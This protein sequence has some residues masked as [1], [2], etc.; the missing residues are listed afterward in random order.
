MR[1]LLVHL[2]TIRILIAQH[3][4]CKFNHHHLHTQTNAKSRYVNRS[5][6]F[7]SNNLT[8]Y[9]ALPET[10]TND[11]T[12]HTAKFLSHILRRNILAV[13]KMNTCPHVV[14]DTSQV[15][16]LPNAFVGILQVVL[17]HQ[18]HMHLAGGV[19]LF[20]KEVAPRFHF[21]HFSY[22]D[23]YFAQNSSIEA[24]PL[25]AHRHLIDAGHILTLHHA[26]K[27]NITKRRHLHAQGIVEVA[28]CSQY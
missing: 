22:R 27:V 16:T 21:R 19:A 8:L 24:L 14:V 9:A 10:R 4:P 25:H 11:N 23:S 13:H 18:R 28:F 3:I 15:Q 7:C 6:I 17:T 26:L 2:G 1:R 12:S 20:V 5:R